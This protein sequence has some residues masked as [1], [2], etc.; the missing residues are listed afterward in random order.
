MCGFS[1]KSVWPHFQRH[2]DSP[3]TG[4][5][6][7]CWSTFPQSFMP[8]RGELQPN[9]AS[10][11]STWQ[12]IRDCC[13]RAALI[14]FTKQARR[15]SHDGPEVDGR[16]E[17]R[18]KTRKGLLN[19][20][21]VKPSVYNPPPVLLL[22]WYVPGDATRASSELRRPCESHR[23][24]SCSDSKGP[25]RGVVMSYSIPGSSDRELAGLGYVNV[26]GGVPYLVR[27]EE[28]R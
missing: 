11:R 26:M 15:G 16:E 25:H 18:F 13:F 24:A 23:Q 27:L 20:R 10:S 28:P 7:F 3:R 4:H 14:I 1:K 6:C 17:N 5:A 8:F 2:C 19:K 9:R 21:E 22:A 12:G